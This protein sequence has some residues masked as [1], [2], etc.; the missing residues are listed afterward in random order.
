MTDYGFIFYHRNISMQ[1]IINQR[2]FI[3]YINHYIKVVISTVDFVFA[4]VCYL[5]IDEYD[6]LINFLLKLFD[7]NIQSLYPTWFS[8]IQK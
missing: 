6:L 3:K 8:R 1:V 2:I 5:I 4:M 7:C